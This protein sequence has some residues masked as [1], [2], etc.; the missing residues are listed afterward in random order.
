MWLDTSG[1]NMG[2]LFSNSFAGMTPHARFSASTRLQVKP[3][4]PH[5]HC[6]QNHAA[7]HYKD[8]NMY[9]FR[10]LKDSVRTKRST[11]LSSGLART[12]NSHR[13]RYPVASPVASV[14][15]LGFLGPSNRT[16]CQCVASSCS[17]DARSPVRFTSLFLVLV[18]RPGAPF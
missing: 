18:V 3:L 15:S 11:A 14:H 6:V 9:L 12:W 13:N 17:S 2:L 8:S 5:R 7:L 1:R 16:G 10:C 4:K